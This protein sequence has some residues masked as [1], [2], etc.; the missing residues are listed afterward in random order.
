M[1]LHIALIIW[2][3]IINIEKKTWHYFRENML[4]AGYVMVCNACYYYLCKQ[5]PLWTFKS[6]YM[7]STTV[8]MLH[9]FIVMPLIIFSYLTRFP[10]TLIKQILYISKWVINSLII[11]WIGLKFKAIEFKHGWSLSWSALMYILMYVFS[12]I[13]SK[14]PRLTG[15]F[16]ILAAVF[17]LGIFNIPFKSQLNVKRFPFNRLRNL[18]NSFK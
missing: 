17:L 2:L 12:N 15:A 9:L 10:K 4:G 16:S 8:K 14:K 7:K 1:A 11:E 3:L 5:K 18:L 6:K 13:I